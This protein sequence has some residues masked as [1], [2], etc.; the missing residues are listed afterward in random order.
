MKYFAN[1]SEIA[2][3]RGKTS[4]GLVVTNRTSMQYLAVFKVT[5]AV[6]RFACNFSDRIIFKTLLLHFSSFLPNVL[7]VFS[8]TVYRKK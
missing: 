5:W 6:F 4:E 3:H 8:V 1:V 2:N 7:Y